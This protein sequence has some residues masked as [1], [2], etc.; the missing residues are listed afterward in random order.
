MVSSLLIEYDYDE[1][2]KMVGE[3]L[4]FGM[5]NSIHKTRPGDSV[6]ESPWGSSPS[7]ESGLR[8]GLRYQKWHD[9]LSKSDGDA[10]SHWHQTEFGHANNS[11]P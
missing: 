6:P 3:P 8:I 9:T 5:R 4:P 2:K 10:G 11:P 7:G 1:M